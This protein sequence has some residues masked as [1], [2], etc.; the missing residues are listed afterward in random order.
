MVVGYGANQVVALIFSAAGADQSGIIGGS[1]KSLSRRIPCGD[2]PTPADTVTEF[3][4]DELPAA[5]ITGLGCCD[6]A[7][8][9]G[10][11]LSNSSERS[12]APDT[13]CA[14]SCRSVPA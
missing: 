2:N 12:P 1:S 11:R 7:Q 6:C 3:A 14:I 13:A 10:Q 9:L 4:F 5:L 8:L